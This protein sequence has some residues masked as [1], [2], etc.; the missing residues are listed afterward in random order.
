MRETRDIHG[1]LANDQALADLA[2]R[3]HGVLSLAQLRAAGVTDDAVDWRLRRKRLHRVHRGVYA[4]GHAR[5]GERGHLWAAVLAVPGGVLS[6]RTAAAVWD[7]CPMPSS[8][9]DV[10]T[11]GAARSTK[12]LRV[13][14]TARLDATEADGLA[15]TTVA[16]TLADLA[17]NNERRLDRMMARAE[18]HRLLDTTALAEQFG[19]PGGRRLQAALS[20][21]QAHG[22]QPTRSELEE[23]FLDEVKRAG[24]PRPEVNARVAGFEVDFVWREQRLIVETDGAATHLTAKAFEEDRRRDALLASAGWRVLRFTW[25][26]V[27][28]GTAA[29]TLRALL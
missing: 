29:R 20:E 1:F 18:H 16:R 3:Q 10:T 24:L 6:H 9:L 12:K 17:A 27:T 28:D 2:A 15:V 7:L 11:T 19:R 4:V 5:L 14:H 26:Q 8:R 22:P 21:L 13:H 23:R 25:R